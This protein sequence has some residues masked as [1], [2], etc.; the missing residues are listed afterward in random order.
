MN[1][2][3]FYYLKISILLK[4]LFFL[5]K[6]KILINIFIYII[7]FLFIN[8]KKKLILVFLIAIFMISKW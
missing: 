1:L 2:N 8:V 3:L 6:D 5:H 7:F 4:Y